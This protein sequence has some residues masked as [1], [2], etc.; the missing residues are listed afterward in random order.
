MAASIHGYVDIVRMLIEAKAQVNTQKEVCCSYHQKTHCT[1][2]IPSVI[3]PAH[4]LT[5]FLYT[6]W[7][8][9]SSPGSSGRKG[10][11]SEATDRG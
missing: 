1:I 4:E 2:I 6:G 8:D 3:V 11:C 7:L 5:V 10:L 9:C